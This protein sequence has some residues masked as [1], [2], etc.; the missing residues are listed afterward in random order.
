MSSIRRWANTKNHP[1]K[2]LNLLTSHRH[3]LAITQTALDNKLILVATACGKVLGTD[4]YPGPSSN[5]A[6]SPN[7]VVL[8]WCS[9]P[10]S[11]LTMEK[12]VDIFKDIMHNPFE[13]YPSPYHITKK[14]FSEEFNFWQEIWITQIVLDLARINYEAPSHDGLLVLSDALEESGCLHTEILQHLRLQRQHYHGCW[15]L[16]LLLNING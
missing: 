7:S 9:K 12:K 2:M 11:I 4:M 6:S 1:G 10:S 14:E 15:V 5:R 13:L 8:K 3:N 16:D